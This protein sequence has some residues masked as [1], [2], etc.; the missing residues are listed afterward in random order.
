MMG[1]ARITH[2]VRAIFVAVF[3]PEYVARDVAS[4]EPGRNL[5]MSGDWTFMSAWRWSVA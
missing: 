5:T 4:C 2:V 1:T 3:G